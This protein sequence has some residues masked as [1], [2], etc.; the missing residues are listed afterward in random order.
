MKFIQN[1]TE[2]ITRFW[3]YMI[4]KTEKS[5][6][7]LRDLPDFS[8]QFKV[9]TQKLTP[10]E[11]TQAALYVPELAIL[12][13]ICQPAPA[14]TIGSGNTRTAATKIAQQSPVYCG[15]DHAREHQ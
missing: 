5:L 11:A 12:L 2:Q 10:E 3:D 14:Q 6:P 4:P 9:Q 15:N 13:A 7:N 8:E 1:L